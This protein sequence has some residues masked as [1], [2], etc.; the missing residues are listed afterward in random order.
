MEKK[1]LYDISWQVTEPEYRADSALSYSTLARYER[2]G[3]SNLNKL[4]DRIETPSLQLGSAVDALITGGEEEFNN[5]FI[6]AEFPKISDTLISIVKSLFNEFAD[7]HNSLINI[8][9]IEVS[10]R[11]K[12]LDFWAGDK[13]D[14]IRAKKVKEDKGCQ[15]YYKLLYI[16]QGK[17]V[18][19]TETYNNVINMVEALKSSDATSF[20]FQSDNPFDNIERF[21]QLKF[22]ATFNNVCYRNMADLIIVDHDKKTVIPVDLKT[23]GKSEYDFYKSFVQ[24]RYE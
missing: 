4:F 18:L 8:P 19:S 17:S 14:N 1:S 7:T 6:V 22:K 20:Y 21:Y 16:A 2:D 10:G 15:E 24:W 9:D 23:S 13:W 12:I 3:F 11:A 5:S